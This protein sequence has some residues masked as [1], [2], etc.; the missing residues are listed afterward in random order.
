VEPILRHY[1]NIPIIL[2]V[3]V[4]TVNR[5]KCD[6][7]PTLA[8]EGDCSVYHIHYTYTSYILIIAAIDL[9]QI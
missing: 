6:P 2:L 5:S 9:K 1:L 7:I 4:I 3:W 8:Y